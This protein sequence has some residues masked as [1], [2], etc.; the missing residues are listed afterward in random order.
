MAMAAA[1]SF[2][3][4]VTSNSGMRVLSIKGDEMDYLDCL[5]LTDHQIPT[6]ATIPPITWREVS[7]SIHPLLMATPDPMVKM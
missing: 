2:V 6:M 5:D 3:V 4:L 1:I 7:S